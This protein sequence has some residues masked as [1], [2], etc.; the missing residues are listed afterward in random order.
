M[1][2]QLN[3]ARYHLGIFGGSGTGKTTYARKFLCNAKATCRFLFDAEGEFARTFGLK[4]CRTSAEFDRAVPT[5]WVCYDPHD[6]FPGD[7]E[8][9]LVWFSKVVFAYGDALPGRKFFV[10]DEFGSHVTPT[11]VPKPVKVILQMGRRYGIDGVFMAQQPNEI[12]DTI[13]S[14]ITETVCFQ[15]TSDTPKTVNFLRKF[16]LDVETVAHLPQFHWISADNRGR[17]ARS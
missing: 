14:Q 12:P 4:A 8:G 7:Q 15:L 2:L 11:N 3:H 10:V 5:G 9:A 17:R 13:L 1:A 6:M 16:G